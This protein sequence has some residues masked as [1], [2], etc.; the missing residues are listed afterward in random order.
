MYTLS[1]TRY[2]VVSAIGFVCLFVGVIK[3]IRIPV[4]VQNGIWAMNGRF[5]PKRAS[6]SI[7]NAII[8]RIKSSKSPMKYLAALFSSTENK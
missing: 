2:I 3:L 7:R 8:L 6:D 4:L 1:G 5:V